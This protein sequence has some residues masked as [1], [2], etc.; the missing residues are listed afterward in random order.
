MEYALGERFASDIAVFLIELKSWHECICFCKVFH[1]GWPG[2]EAS[3]NHRYLC[4][5]VIS[6]V[7]T[8]TV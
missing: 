7:Q 6:A 5:I 8:T 1:R 4:N 2:T 3:K